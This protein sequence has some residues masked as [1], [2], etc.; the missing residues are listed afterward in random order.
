MQK[1]TSL[2]DLAARGK[3]IGK[4][5]D[6]QPT[7]PQRIPLANAAIEI[8][9][10]QLDLDADQVRQCALHLSP[11]ELLRANRFHFEH[12]RRRFIVARATLRMLLGGCLAVKPNAIAL[13]YTR[14]GKPVVADHAAGIHFNVSHAHERALY[15]ISKSC[16]L[17][18]DI[19]YL[20][21]DVDYSGLAERFFTRRECAALQRIPEPDRKRAFFACWTRKEAVIKATG[22]GLSLP[23]DQFDVTVA[24][25]G[26]PRVLDSAVASHAGYWNLYGPDVGHDYVA[27]VAAH[28]RG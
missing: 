1:C 27:A 8:W 9:L 19:E 12:D 16:A 6:T 11:D 18:V 15:A 2:R 24:P 25:E 26:A 14:N 20:N 23:L 13:G 21:R 10:T 22:D 5:E 28:Y 4:G 3:R 7:A 17:G